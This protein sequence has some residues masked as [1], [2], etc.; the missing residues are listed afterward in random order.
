MSKDKDLVAALPGSTRGDKDNV[1]VTNHVLMPKTAKLPGTSPA[2][3][4]SARA[5]APHLL[6]SGNKIPESQEARMRSQFASPDPAIYAQKRKTDQRMPQ[7]SEN[8][9][10][11]DNSRQP[12]MTCSVYKTEYN[13]GSKG[14]KGEPSAKEQARAKAETKKLMGQ[15]EAILSN[16]CSTGQPGSSD[17][18]RAMNIVGEINRK[19]GLPYNNTG[20]W[21][22]PRE[23]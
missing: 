23:Y 16:I 6:G 19:L 5:P 20:S 1:G 2:S 17:V 9:W 21:V 15:K 4:A 8:W 3:D 22:L 7:N 12:L 13:T 11:S 10:A 14:G 18:Y